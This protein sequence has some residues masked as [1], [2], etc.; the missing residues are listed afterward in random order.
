MLLFVNAFSFFCMLLLRCFD[1]G[2]WVT[3][4]WPVKN[5]APEFPKVL[6]WK[7]YGGP[8]ITWSNLRKNGLDK[9]KPKVENS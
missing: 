2:D 8:G 9:Q 7:I 4:I 3:G 1:A 6:L 5:P